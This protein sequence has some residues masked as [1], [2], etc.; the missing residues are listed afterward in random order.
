VHHETLSGCCVLISEVLCGH[1]IAFKG[2]SPEEEGVGKGCV[3]LRQRNMRLNSFNY[4]E[5]KLHKIPCLLRK[6]LFSDCPRLLGRPIP[7]TRR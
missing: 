2:L 7:T 5:L 4:L 6:D 1:L 3:V